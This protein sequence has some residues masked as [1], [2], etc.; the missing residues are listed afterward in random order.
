[1][2]TTTLVL[3]HFDLA[4]VQAE[5]T[6][7]QWTWALLLNSAGRIISHISDKQMKH[8]ASSH[9]DRNEECNLAIDAMQFSRCARY[10]NAANIFNLSWWNKGSG[11]SLQ[12]IRKKV[13]R[14][15][16]GEP[17]NRELYLYTLCSRIKFRSQT[18]LTSIIQKYGH[19]LRLYSSFGPAI[20]RIRA[21][22]SRFSNT[23]TW[24]NGLLRG[25]RCDL[26]PA[27]R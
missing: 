8:F 9:V 20:F 10:C 24:P 12:R 17:Y 27:N 21:E 23:S 18:D 26:R 15:V 6:R 4:Q 7:L 3:R 22:M 19:K 11:V 16:T 1:M 25:V 13:I 2:C 14:S 5:F